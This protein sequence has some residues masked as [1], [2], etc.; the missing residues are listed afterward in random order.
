MSLIAGLWLLYGGSTTDAAEVDLSLNLTFND[1]TDI[2][3]GGTWTVVA[4]ADESG[5]AGLSLD[6]VADSLN[7]EPAT[8]FLTPAGFEVENSAVFGLRLNIVQGDDLSDPT[9]DVGVVGGSFPSSYVDA[10]NLDPILGNPD[11]GSFSGGVELATGS[12]DAGDIPEWFG[13]SGANVF[14]SS[15]RAIS[16]TVSTTV[17]ASLIPEPISL[18][19]LALSTAPMA[20]IRRRK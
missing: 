4:K 17:R 9:L 7:F 18:V 12:F 13:T 16:A 8:G 2:N 1:P 5:I 11:L 15:S 20:L 14:D 19:L 10:P 3:S 6:F